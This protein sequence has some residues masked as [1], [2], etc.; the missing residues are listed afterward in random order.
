VLFLLLA[1]D[2]GPGIAKGH[3]AIEDELLR[4]GIFRIHAEVADPLE[5]EPA[6][7]CRT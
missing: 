1:G 4:R 3:D 2:F 5:L 7:R 6:A